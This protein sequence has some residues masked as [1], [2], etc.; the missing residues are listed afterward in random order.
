M[1]G[2]FVSRLTTINQY[3]VVSRLPTNQAMHGTSPNESL[4][5]TADAG[6]LSWPANSRRRVRVGVGLVRYAE[7][8]RQDSPGSRYSAHPGKGIRIKSVRQPERL[9]LALWLRPPSTSALGGMHV[10]RGAVRPLQGRRHPRVAQPRAALRGYR[11]EAGPGLW[12]WG[13]FGAVNSWN[14]GPLELTFVR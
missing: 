8:V 3:F 14:S 11:R 10:A 7:S 4:N 5:P 13:P 2:R 1:S 12:G 6:C 9:Q